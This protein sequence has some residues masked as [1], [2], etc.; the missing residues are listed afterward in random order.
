MRVLASE[1]REL[2]AAVAIGFWV[3]VGEPRVVIS[4]A[5]VL[6]SS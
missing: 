6:G 4:P 1:G 3:V 2:V 5:S